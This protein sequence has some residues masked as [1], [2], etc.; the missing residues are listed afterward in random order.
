MGGIATVDVGI[1]ASIGCVYEE[2]RS[3]SRKIIVELQLS[4]MRTDLCDVY[5]CAPDSLS[6]VGAH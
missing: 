5:V 3:S 1:H 4:G 2:M 6:S